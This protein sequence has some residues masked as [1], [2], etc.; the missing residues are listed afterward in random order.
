[1]SPALPGDKTFE[2]LKAELKA[3][4]MAHFELIS[5]TITERYPFHNMAH[6]AGESITNFAAY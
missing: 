4:S 3:E 2:E 5:S 1:M 6:A